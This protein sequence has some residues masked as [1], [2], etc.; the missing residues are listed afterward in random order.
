MFGKMT[1]REKKLIGLALVAALMAFLA[2]IPSLKNGFINWDDNLYVYENPDIHALNFG[3]LRHVFTSYTAFNWHP[4]TII[5]YA[6]DYRLMGLDPTVYHLTNI[7]F[8]SFNTFLIALLAFKLCESAA[9]DWAI[10]SPRPDGATPALVV[11]FITAL[12][13]GLHPQHVESVT[14]VS[15]RKDVLYSFFFILST[16]SYLKYSSQRRYGSYILALL[17]F[18]LSI[19]SKPMA[20]S[21]PIVLLIIDYYPLNRFAGSRNNIWSAGRLLLEKVPFFVLSALSSILTMNAQKSSLASIVVVGLMTRLSVAVRGYMFY[22]YKMVISAKLAPIYPYPE[23]V[24]LVSLEYMGSFILFAGIS[25]FALLVSRK[26]KIFIAVWAYYLITLLPVIGI[27]Q[28]GAQSA[29]DRYTYLPSVGPFM[30]AGVGIAYLMEK[31]DASNGI[32]KMLAP[33]VVSVAGIG[34]TIFSYQTLRQQTFW[35]DSLTLWNYE[36]KE[37]PRAY[38]AYHDRGVIYMYLHEYTMAL[39]DLNKAIEINPN[40]SFLSFYTRGTVYH[41]KGDDLLAVKDFRVAAAIDPR[42]SKLHNDLGISYGNLGRYEEAVKEFDRA[43]EL[44]S[45]FGEAF[46]NR[47]YTFLKIGKY[48]RAIEDL[49]KALELEPGNASVCNSLGSAY[50]KVGDAKQS[51]FYFEKA[52]R[53]SK[54]GPQTVAKDKYHAI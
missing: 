38:P 21:L 37:F 42:S 54:E 51:K 32:R 49:R 35:K 39:D 53:A 20:V 5:S 47:G 16:L 45:K 48:D 10:E 22:L 17:F 19:M 7:I 15:E 1:R 11:S 30:L 29:A 34:L 25:L 13:F 31:S 40:A 18:A 12:L 4:L 8:H 3:F 33:V 26:Y 14:W 52:S 44:D 50:A 28:V 9:P 6:L 46:N 36:L 23:H 27:I 2:Y 24:V 43:V 41:M